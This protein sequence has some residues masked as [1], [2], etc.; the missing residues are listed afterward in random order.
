MKAFA[1]AAS[2]GPDQG[3]RGAV[4]EARAGKRPESEPARLVHNDYLEQAS[5]SG[6][7]GFLSYTAFMIGGLA[8]TYKKCCLNSE[9]RKDTQQQRWLLFGIWL[10]LLGWALQG[11]IE[12]G[13]YVP[14]EA[15]PAF[16]LFGWLIQRR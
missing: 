1:T 8:W 11:L 12:F 5:D 7:V 9:V 13:L 3:G 15:W 2:R 10:G 16:A 6:I 4:S 14:G